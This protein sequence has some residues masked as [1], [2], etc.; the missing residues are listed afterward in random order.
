MHIAASAS[1]EEWL[2]SWSGML[3]PVCPLKLAL[4]GHPD[5]GGHWEAHCESHLSSVGFERIPDWHSTFWHP[6]FKLLLIVYVDD[7][8]LSGPKCNLEGLE[9]APERHHLRDTNSIGSYLGCLHIQGSYTLP[10]KTK[11]RTVTYDMESF[12]TS[13]VELYKSL[14]PPSFKL[15]Y[16]PT[17]FPPEG[18]KDDGP[19]GNPAVIDGKVVHCP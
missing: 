15:K 2:K 18:V 9:V 1:T 11:V 14:A 17:P 12:L 7:F 16:M 10:D 6:Q 19:A 13:C 8:K 3:R 4:Y 5:A